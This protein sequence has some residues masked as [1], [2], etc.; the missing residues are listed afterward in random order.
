MKRALFFVA[1]A[2][3]SSD[4]QPTGD[5]GSDVVTQNDAGGGDSGSDSPANLDQQG[6][7]FGGYK[8]TSFF[9]ISVW[10][11]SPPNAPAYAAIGVNQ[12]IGLYNGPVQSD[13]DTL[14]TAKMPAYCDQNSV[15]LAN[16]TN[17][18]IAGWTQEDEPD[19]AQ[20]VDGGY[21][22]CI[23]PS[24]IQSLYQTMK[25][26]DATRPVFLNVGQGVA[27]DAW[28]GRG[29]CSNQPQDYPEYA[30]GADIVSFDIYPINSGLDITLIALGV[31]RLNQA[32]AEK[33]PVWN[34]IE[35]TRIDQANPKPTPDQ[36][37]AEVW[38][39]II[40]GSMG[41]GY[42][43]HQFTP[44]FDEKALLDD[45]V[46]KPAVAAINQQIHDL[47]PALDTPPITNAIATNAST[48]IDTLVKRQGG[49]LYVFAVSMGA[50]QGSATFTLAHDTFTTATVLGENR[51]VTISANAFQDSF[52]G[53]AVH[54]Y[55]LE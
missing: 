39:S 55:Q 9:P 42:F 38:M 17:P 24:E 6:P 19:N 16:L 8:D 3:C 49:K 25:T 52:A 4:A 29:S 10:L 18:I 34:W 11:Q 13:L 43:V 1:L 46:M 33:K 14:T 26:K 48:K 27:N 45:A 2:A 15:G 35:C 54:L 47:A 7:W 21:G 32:V 36:V 28:V 5:A 51:T 37:K 50:S 12:F 44:T 23:A 40:H 31:D 22:P 53:Y 30:K 41:I 20:P